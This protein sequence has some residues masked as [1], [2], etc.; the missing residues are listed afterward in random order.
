MHNNGRQRLINQGCLFL[1]PFIHLF[2]FFKS[3]FVCLVMYWFHKLLIKPGVCLYIVINLQWDLLGFYYEVFT[4]ICGSHDFIFLVYFFKRKKD[5]RNIQKQT[6]N[7][8]FDLVF[9]FWFRQKPRRFFFRF[10]FKNP[11]MKKTLLLFLVSG[12]VI[13]QPNKKHY[14]RNDQK[15]KMNRFTWFSVFWFLDTEKVFICFSFC[16]KKQI[17]CIFVFSTTNELL[18]PWPNSHTNVKKS[19]TN[20]KN[21]DC[22]V[23]VCSE[24][25]QSFYMWKRRSVKEEVKVKNRQ[26]KL[27]TSQRSLWEKQRIKVWHVG[28]QKHVAA[29]YWSMTKV[30]GGQGEESS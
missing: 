13:F 5:K 23:K 19:V 1:A 29:S 22:V 30:G 17:Y 16:G 21:N 6:L 26:N 10:W 14:K 24:N 11:K 12:V 9:G 20:F 18:I 4:F 25:M 27:I 3:V 15:Q 8:Y 28:G 2:C 7:C